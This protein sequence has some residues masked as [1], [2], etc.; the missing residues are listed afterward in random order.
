MS[1]GPLQKCFLAMV[2][3]IIAFCPSRLPAQAPDGSGTLRGQVTDPSGS[4]IGTAT[5]IVTTP[6]GD[7][8]TASTNRDGIYEVKTP[9]PGRYG[10]KIIARG[11]PEFD[12]ADVEIATG[13]LQKVDARLAIETQAEK[14]VAPAQAAAALDVNPA[15]NA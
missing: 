13:Q 2:F 3:A 7:A 8:I 15:S 9:P 11:F 10:V 12:K 1:F 5:V 14:V 6:A 4:A